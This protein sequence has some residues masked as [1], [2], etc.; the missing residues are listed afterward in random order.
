[1]LDCQLFYPMI[2]DAAMTIKNG[3]ADDLKGGVKSEKARIV[4]QP[5]CGQVFYY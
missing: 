4:V 2:A 5:F 1:M 3:Y